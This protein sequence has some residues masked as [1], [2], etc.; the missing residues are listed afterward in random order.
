MSRWANSS[1]ITVSC[2]ISSLWLRKLHHDD[3]EVSVAGPA[4]PRCH[5]LSGSA[6]AVD[7]MHHARWRPTY[8]LRTHG[9][10]PFA[11]QH[12]H[13]TPSK[14]CI[15]ASNTQ[16]RA[17]WNQH[18]QCTRRTHECGFTQ[19]TVRTVLLQYYLYLHAREGMVICVMRSQ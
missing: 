11:T 5:K 2:S 19:S 9:A 17:S 6:V 8:A 4:S 18:T 12:E 7:Q 14:H 15:H 10:C 1:H 16:T 3:H 13:C